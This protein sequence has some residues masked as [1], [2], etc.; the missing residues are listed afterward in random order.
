LSLAQLKKLR[1]MMCFLL[2]ASWEKWTDS[3]LRSASSSRATTSVVSRA[4][5]AFSARLDEALKL[6]QMDSG[7][8]FDYLATRA[9]VAPERLGYVGFSWGAITGITFAAHDELW[10]AATLERFGGDFRFTRTW[11]ETYR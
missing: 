9:D 4:L 5:R 3:H 1:R 10:R 2:I 6:A 11:R 8:R 7:Q